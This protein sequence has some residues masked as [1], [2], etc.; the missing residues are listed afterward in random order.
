MHKGHADDTQVGREV[1]ALWRPSHVEHNRPKCMWTGIENVKTFAFSIPDVDECKGGCGYLSSL[2]CLPFLDPAE[3]VY[4]V[5][6][7]QEPFSK[8]P[9]VLKHAVNVV[10]NWKYAFK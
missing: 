10:C 5:I 1:F 9:Y 4:V 3:Q 8:E 6:C 7:S 2:T